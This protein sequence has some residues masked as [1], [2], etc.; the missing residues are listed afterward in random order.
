MNI[1]VASFPPAQPFWIRISHQNADYFTMYAGGQT[2]PLLLP[3]IA[4]A[5]YDDSGGLLATVTHPREAPVIVRFGPI[6]RPGDVGSPTMLLSNR[7]Y[8]IGVAP[9]GS[10]FHQN[11]ISDF[12]PATGSVVVF[13][14]PTPGTALPFA[15][16]GLLTIRRRRN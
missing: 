8:F 15:A 4:L 1:G 5:L 14:A 11:Y 3:N 13:A 7:Y 9:G 6:W 12:V 10:V 2:E 16:L